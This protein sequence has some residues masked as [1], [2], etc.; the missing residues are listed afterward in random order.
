MARKKFYEER[1]EGDVDMTPMLDIVFILLIFFIVTTSFVREEGLEVNRPKAQKSAN[2]QNNPVIVV[3]ISETGLV[4]FNGKIVD[5]ERLPARI[6]NY[7][8]TNNTNS[9]VVIPNVDTTHE[10]V[11][12]V[13]DKIKIFDHLT[14]SIGK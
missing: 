12:N 14:I 11:V 4:S 7:L 1:N 9:A 5:I 6:E 10:H 2:N 3:T 8:A 13:I